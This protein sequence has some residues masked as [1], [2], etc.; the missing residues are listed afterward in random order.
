MKGVN[1][2]ELCDF[3][4]L[5]KDDRIS[6]RFLEFMPFSGNAWSQRKF[7]PYQAQI[8]IIE[9][10]FGKLERQKDEQSST[11][12]VGSFSSSQF[13]L[14]IDDN[15]EDKNEHKTSVKTNA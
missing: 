3:V 11:S 1:E 5:T 6:V 15:F 14:W 9:E 12:M 8:S 2:D 13:I 10:Q 7:I 4:Y